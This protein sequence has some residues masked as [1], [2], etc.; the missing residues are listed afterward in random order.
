M[1][2]PMFR[3]LFIWLIATACLLRAADVTASLS[4]DSVEAGQGS[5]LTIRIDGESIRGRPE[6]P[7]VP[8]L[9]I[10]ARGQS[11][12]VRI[13][14]G[15]MSREIHFNYIVGSYTAGDY[16]IPPI[17][18]TVDGAEFRT[19]E[20]KLTVRP[21]ASGVPQGME[22]EGEAPA[23]AG[24]Y[25]HLVFQM[26]KKDRKHVY[27]GEIAP[28]RIQAFFPADARVS[29]NGPPRPDGAAFTLHNLSGEPR[30]EL[31]VVDGKQFNVITW[32]GGLSATKAGSWPAGF[33]LEGNITV[34]DRSAARQGRP[35]VDPLF[36]GGM[37]DDFF[38]PMV[39]KDVALEIA[40]P[41]VIEVREL[42]AEGRPD[43]FSGAIGEFRFSRVRM[44]ET[45]ETGEPVRIEASIEGS[46]NFSLLDRPRPLPADGWK[47]YDGE[48]EFLPGDAASFG[49]TK[50]FSFNA[51]PREPGAKQV[52]LGFSYFDPEA[53]EYRRVESD[54]QAVTIRGEAVVESQP[55]ETAAAEPAPPQE[56]GLAP[57]RREAGA[58]ARYD[59]PAD[60]PWFVPALAGC[61]V[62]SLA[63]LGFGAWR[64]RHDD[65]AKEALRQARLAEA[66][67]LAAAGEAA[68]RNDA[69]AF[70]T[71]AREALR[72]AAAEA[73]GMR[74]EAV[75]LDD[76]HGR[77]EGPALDL[78]RAA[79]HIH[80]SGA[81]PETGNLPAWRDALR[82]GMKSLTGGRIA[83]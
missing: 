64:S 38:A 30:Q 65:P 47:S 70:L 80:Y 52:K 63:I 44:P 37:L 60:E 46:G 78:W 17:T 55:Q 4:T 57:I 7:Q 49:G 16:V 19:D 6:I 43:D 45:M 39:R 72:I 59:S 82:D 83:G 51:V 53:G 13:I 1:V 15:Q 22:E 11:Q 79:D 20:L 14:N 73:S 66:R 21:S 61:G 81:P 41:P 69:P 40:E 36:G 34:R 10:E 42:P 25:G 35:S 71:A 58:V 62:L 2:I 56:P 23:D 28:V 67:A 5:V 77:L 29:L 75:T 68:E 27:P 18:L 3:I 54:P 9:V 31:Q 76:L 24:E 12:Q 8:N 74:P 48:D 33:S 50:S 32:F 26:L